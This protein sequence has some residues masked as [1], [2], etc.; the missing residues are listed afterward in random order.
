MLSLPNTRG[1]GLFNIMTSKANVEPLWVVFAGNQY[2][3][4]VAC[5]PLQFSA[6]EFLQLCN[7]CRLVIYYYINKT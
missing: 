6:K 7:K 1:H 4:D 3:T 2:I 5:K